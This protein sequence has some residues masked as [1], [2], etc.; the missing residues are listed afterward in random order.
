[1]Q[2]TETDIAAL[3]EMQE[4][5]RAAAVSQRKL[6]ELPQKRAIADIRQQKA[7]MLKKK[8][9]VQDM[10]D[11]AEEAFGKAF[12]E[13]EQLA[14]KQAEAEEGVKE[15]S[16]DFRAVEARS[17]ALN[18][19]VKRRRTL[20]DEL[21]RLEAQ[22]EKIK[23]V[24]AQLIEVLA[25]LDSKEH[26]SI[27]SYQEEGRA[28]QSVILQAQK[29]RERLAP[30]VSPEALSAFEQAKKA[31]GAIAVARLEGDSCSACRTTIDH[32]RLLQVRA[33]APLSHCPNC[34]RLLVVEEG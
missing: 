30:T 23:P 32:G 31:C 2:A 33:E 34:R 14:A 1:M 22:V 16:G 13:D 5:Q 28:L 25:A 10:L 6:D 26:A 4:A 8:V 17:K 11:G 3:L 7:Q 19:V 20:A 21:V 29:T 24:L 27:V 15:A 18:G 12:A 9:Q